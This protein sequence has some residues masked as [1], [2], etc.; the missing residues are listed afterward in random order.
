M[1]SQALFPPCT[2]CL[3]AH[4]HGHAVSALVDLGSSHNIMQ[5]RAASYLHLTVQPL[6]CFVVMVGNGASL[7]YLGLRLLVLLA[8][9]GHCL[10]IPFY[11]LPIHGAN[12]VLG[13]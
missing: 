3:C 8:I 12:V 5:P 4:I 13:V 9:Q 1:P 11:L 7:T 10:D 6:P 2:L